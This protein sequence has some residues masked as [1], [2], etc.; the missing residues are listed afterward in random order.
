[1]KQDVSHSMYILLSSCLNIIREVFQ[2][3]SIPLRK[4]KVTITN[5][6]RILL[7]LQNTS[8]VLYIYGIL[9]L[10]VIK[11]LNELTFNANVSLIM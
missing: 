4:D 11:G 10:S 1:M 2:I 7:F 3:I 5:Y 8:T 6:K 9:S